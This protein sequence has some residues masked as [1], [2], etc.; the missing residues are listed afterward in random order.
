MSDS[1]RQRPKGALWGIAAGLRDILIGR[2]H[3]LLEAKVEYLENEVSRL[4][5]ILR[6][7]PAM[8][9]VSQEPA[10]TR[11]SFDFQWGE[12]PSGRH[13]MDNESFRKEAVSNVLSYTQLPAEWFRGKK[14]AD[15]GCGSGRYSWALCMLGANVTSFDQS[16]RGLDAA[17]KACSGFPGHRAVKANALEPFGETGEYD[18]VWCYGVLHHTGDTYMAFKNVC[19]LVRPGGHAFFMLYGEPRRWILGDYTEINEYEEWRKKTRNMSFP[20]KRS[21]IS[22]ALGEGGLSVKGEEHLNGFFDAISPQVNDLYRWDEIE[23]W[24]AEEGF[25]EIRRTAPGRNLHLIAKKSAAIKSTE[26][27]NL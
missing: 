21:A 4:S 6:R 16:D 13:M 26:V 1:G 11:D 2:R 15:V 23:G 12:I 7:V 18:L 9:A 10:Q 20:E 5:S 19:S 17:V 24:L 25:C 3:R 8:G 14:I 22:K 27:S